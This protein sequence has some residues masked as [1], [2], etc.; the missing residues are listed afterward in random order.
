ME[1]RRCHSLINVKNSFWRGL[2]L[3]DWQRQPTNFYIISIVFMLIY[4][5][6]SRGNNSEWIINDSFHAPISFR[7]FEANQLQK[8]HRC[9]SSN[10]LPQARFA[11]KLKQTVNFH[12]L[13]CFVSF[14]SHTQVKKSRIFWNPASGFANCGRFLPSVLTTKGPRTGGF[15]DMRPV[16]CGRDV[17]AFKNISTG[18]YVYHHPSPNYVP[19][20]PLLVLFW[21]LLLQAQNWE[22]KKSSEINTIDFL[23]LSGEKQKFQRGTRTPK[24]KKKRKNS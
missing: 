1:Q 4:T 12:F 22:M 23:F 3:P 16:Y 17:S 15:T 7:V 5:R 10:L 20:P 19:T 18:Q 8:Q 2:A 24:R 13:S 6:R 21:H 9:L 11:A 14:H